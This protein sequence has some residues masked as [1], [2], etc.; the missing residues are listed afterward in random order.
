MGATFRFDLEGPGGAF[1][2]ELEVMRTEV[3]RVVAIEMRGTLPA[4]EV[5]TIEP[6]PDDAAGPRSRVSVALNLRI[7]DEYPPTSDGEMLAGGLR[8]LADELDA[9]AVAMGERTDP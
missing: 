1:P 2:I 4:A 6:L 3:D 5:F 9:M 8:Q 7:P